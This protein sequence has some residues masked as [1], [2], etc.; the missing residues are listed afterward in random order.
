MNYDQFLKNN[1]IKKV[2]PNADQIRHQIKRSEQD[3]ETAQAN[4]TIDTTWSLTIAYHAMIRACRAMMYAQ[5]YLPTAHQTHKTLV[6]FAKAFLGEKYS[7]LVAKLNRLRRRRHSFIYDAK[8]HV[9]MEE[10]RSALAAAKELIVQIKKI[11]R[12]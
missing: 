7:N 5:G 1:L 10:A 3:L 4:L 12:K 6:E 11:V 2:K 9:N 8:N